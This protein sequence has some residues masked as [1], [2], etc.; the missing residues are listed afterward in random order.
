[1]NI[2]WLNYANAAVVEGGTFVQNILQ[3]LLLRSCFKVS[4]IVLLLILS[5]E[6][7]LS[8]TVMFVI[9]IFYISSIALVLHLNF[10]FL[11]III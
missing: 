5:K 4:T 1:M 8:P 9:A 11:L 3:S 10:I 6:P 7:I 2:K